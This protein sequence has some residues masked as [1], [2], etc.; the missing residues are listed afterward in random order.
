VN[1]PLWEEGGMQV[2]DATRRYLLQRAGH[3]AAAQRQR[4][5]GVGAGAGT[6][7]MPQVLVAEGM[8]NACWKACLAASCKAARLSMSHR[9]ATEFTDDLREQ[10]VRHLVRLLSATLKLPPQKHR[11]EAQ[12]SRPTASIR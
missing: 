1:W 9:V 6:A 3:D 11:C 10:T 7:A 8:A 2:D 12:G 5:R 4:L